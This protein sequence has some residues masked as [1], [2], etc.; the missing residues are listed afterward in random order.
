MDNRASICVIR[1]FEASPQ[2]AYQSMLF[3]IDWRATLAFDCFIT[4][5]VKY[6]LSRRSTYM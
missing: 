5:K 3:I 2:N 6:V 1:Y 4:L